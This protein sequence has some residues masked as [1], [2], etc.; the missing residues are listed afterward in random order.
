MKWSHVLSEKLGLLPLSLQQASISYKK[1]KK[2]TKNGSCND[3]VKELEKDCKRTDETFKK[4]YSAI[5]KGSCF[6]TYFSKDDIKLFVDLNKT[7]IYKVC[8]RI[9]KKISPAPDARSWL[10]NSMKSHMYQ[11]MGGWR[12]TSLSINLPVECP[13]CMD[14]SER[15]AISKC[16]HFMC[17][18]C[19]AIQKQRFV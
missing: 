9:D 3:I 4:V 13:L 11:F 8:K 16:G 7:S 19:T 2:H 12:I 15:V 17:T 5:S 14:G 6:F 1:W 10:Q 18:Q